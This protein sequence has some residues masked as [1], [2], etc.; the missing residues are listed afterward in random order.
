MPGAFLAAAF[1]PTGFLTE[2]PAPPAVQPPPDGSGLRIIH[3]RRP[4]DR[5][6][7]PEDIAREQCML[8]EY[9]QSLEKKEKKLERAPARERKKATLA[10]PAPRLTD[11][12]A[13]AASAKQLMSI[14]RAV[15]AAELDRQK[16]AEEKRRRALT[17]VLLLALD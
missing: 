11:A 1:L 13:R 17:A 3:G 7:L 12:M 8:E 10:T 5:D 16:A 2:T 9:V 6:R 4:R 15:S 14:M